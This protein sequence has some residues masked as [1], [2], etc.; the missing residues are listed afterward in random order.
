M[1]PAPRPGPVC[2]L[3]VKAAGLDQLGGARCASCGALGPPGR[4][5][6]PRGP[7]LVLQVAGKDRTAHPPPHTQSSNSTPHI[8]F[9][10]IQ[11]LRQKGSHGGLKDSRGLLALQLSEPRPAVWPMQRLRP[12]ERAAEGPAQLSYLFVDLR[13]LLQV[14]LQE[15]DFLL[16][17][18]AAPAVVAVQLH[19]LH[20]H[21]GSARRA[22]HCPPSAQLGAGQTF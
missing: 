21:Q 15:G 20:R 6:S 16:L 12:G 14:I 1:L 13:E 2:L 11:Y 4:H 5:Q 17:G 22:W 9:D 3:S 18:S 19:T 7:R 8:G 10:E